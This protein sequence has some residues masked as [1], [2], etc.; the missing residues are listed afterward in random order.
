MNP[1]NPSSFTDS[2]NYNPAGYVTS[3]DT[4]APAAPSAPVTGQVARRQ[5]Q[6]QLVTRNRGYEQAPTVHAENTSDTGGESS[7]WGESLDQ[8]YQRAL[9]A[10]R[11]AQA[12]RKQIPPFVQKLSRYVQRLTLHCAS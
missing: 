9:A 2:S 11:D 3:Q 7:A 12:K 4:A 1:I 5:A 10:K 8:L 6:N